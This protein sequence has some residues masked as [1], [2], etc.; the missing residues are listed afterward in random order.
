MSY[1]L[2]KLNG[3]KFTVLVLLI[4]VNDDP[5]I[6]IKSI[7]YYTHVMFFAGALSTFGQRELSHGGTYH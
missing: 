6:N 5:L 7:T 2:F 3:K 1:R 4:K